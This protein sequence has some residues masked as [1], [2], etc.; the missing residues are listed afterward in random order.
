M[1]KQDAYLYLRRKGV[2][3]D[4]VHFAPSQ[5]LLFQQPTV[6]IAPDPRTAHVI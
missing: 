5:P 3:S 6:E 4:V 1:I 2:I